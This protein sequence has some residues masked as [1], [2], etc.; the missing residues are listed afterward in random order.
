MMGWLRPRLCWIARVAVVLMALQGIGPLLHERAA[1]AVAAG[2]G[3]GVEGLRVAICTATGLRTVTFDPVSGTWSDPADGSAG[4]PAPGGALAGPHC[5]ICLG[6][7]VAAVTPALGSTLAVR[8]TQGDDGAVRGHAPAAVP[9][10]WRG[11][12]LGSRAPPR[13]SA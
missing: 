5:P 3:S 11:P 8:S 2:A 1:A 9:S 10:P 12:P 7:G 13:R 4:E 6:P